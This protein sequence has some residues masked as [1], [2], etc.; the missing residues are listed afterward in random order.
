DKHLNDV[1]H[2]AFYKQERRPQQEYITTEV[3]NNANA[4]L[5]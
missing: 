2:K 5:S 3:T 4:Q 1:A